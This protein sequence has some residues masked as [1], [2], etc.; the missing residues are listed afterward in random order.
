MVYF[1]PR[2]AALPAILSARNSFV[3]YALRVNNAADSV[4]K[5][6][7][8]N[9]YEALK[10][11]RINDKGDCIY[12][13]VTKAVT[14]HHQK[15]HGYHHCDAAGCRTNRGFAPPD[16]HSA[17]PWRPQSQP[18]SPYRSPLLQRSRHFPSGTYEYAKCA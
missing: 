12:L 2:L 11:F 15:R 1:T 10:S 4:I 9:L 6:R 7:K 16:L 5:L 8:T 18:R 17:I 3:F 14:S 13:I